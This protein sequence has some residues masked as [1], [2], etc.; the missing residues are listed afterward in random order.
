MKDKS[1]SRR[2][3]AVPFYGRG[4]CLLCCMMVYMKFSHEIQQGSSLLSGVVVFHLRFHSC[5]TV[6]MKWVYETQQDSKRFH[7]GVIDVI[8]I[9]LVTV[10]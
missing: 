4:L 6:H 10:V 8:L 2:E 3:E 5:L 7:P 1:L 9:R